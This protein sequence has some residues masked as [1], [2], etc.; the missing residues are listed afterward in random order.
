MAT[1]ASATAGQLS[2]LANVHY[3]ADLLTTSASAVIVTSAM[4][5]LCPG[6]ALISKNPYLSY[7]QA[8]ALFSP[9]LTSYP[10]IH[11]SAIVSSSASISTSASVAANA[12]IGD[13]VRIGDNSHIGPGSVIGDGVQIAQDCLLKGNVSIYHGV[14]I[15]ARVI[16]HSGVVLGSDGFGYAPGAGSKRW[17]KIHQLGGVRIGDD[18]EIGANT[19][20]DRGALDDTIIGNGVIIDNLVQIAHNVVIGDNTAIA[21][22]T[23]IA[24]SCKIGNN[25]TIA[26]RASILGHLSIADGCHITTNSL[27]SKSIDKPGSY[28]SGT[29]GVEPTTQWRKNAVRFSKL[30]E[31]YQRLLKLEKNTRD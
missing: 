27:V 29:A 26:G 22:C 20:I 4:A 8:S 31:M 16:L 30:N 25:C 13:G 17:H 28:S 18:V 6:N 12:V 10:G 1:L 9:P 21:G 11:R 2:F 7:A 3:Q 24:G 5:K 14:T 19:V 15:G 23:A